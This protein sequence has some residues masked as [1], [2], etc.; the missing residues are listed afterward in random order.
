[1][2]AEGEGWTFV[3]HI[4]MML[5]T[6][7]RNDAIVWSGRRVVTGSNWSE[8]WEWAGRKEII[9]IFR[10]FSLSERY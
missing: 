8:A 4:Q 3:E 7:L 1:M 10:F 9:I 6:I 2:V 5:S